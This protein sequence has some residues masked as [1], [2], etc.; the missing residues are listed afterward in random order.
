MYNYGF[1][2]TGIVKETFVAERSSIPV[3]LNHNTKPMLK[4]V[5]MK[6][7]LHNKKKYG[8]KRADEMLRANTVRRDSRHG[9]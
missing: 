3:F 1:K 5:D 4:G 9:E 7:Y 2:G 6:K 8:K